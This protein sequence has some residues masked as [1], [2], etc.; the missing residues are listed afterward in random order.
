MENQIEFRI[1]RIDQ[2]S[3]SLN[4]PKE[5]LT[6]NYTFTFD[7]ELNNSIDMDNEQF[8]VVC[9]VHVSST[10]ASF[11]FASLEIACI[12]KIEQFT[13]HIIK[14]EATFEVPPV[15][16]TSTNSITISTTRGA[17]FGLFKGTFLHNAVLPI[18]N[19]ANLKNK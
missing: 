8:I 16:V 12:F 4:P 2:G 13:K 10:D 5:P 15:F 11:R 9:S 17:M 19:P 7:V 1:E 3:F 6:N 14:K 18:I